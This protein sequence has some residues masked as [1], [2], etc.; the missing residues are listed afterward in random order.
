MA[1]NGKAVIPTQASPAQNPE[2]ST[3]PLQ[4]QT[5][6]EGNVPRLAF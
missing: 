4:E 3:L 5:A 1:A 2:H 6:I